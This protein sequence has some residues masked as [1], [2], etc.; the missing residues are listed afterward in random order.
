M[1]SFPIIVQRHLE[2]AESQFT[3]HKIPVKT[4][5]LKKQCHTLDPLLIEIRINKTYEL[6][7]DLL[8]NGKKS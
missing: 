6:A 4:Q 5:Q 1:H 2:R 3:L 8:T 7:T